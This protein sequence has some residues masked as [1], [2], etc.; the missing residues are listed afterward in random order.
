MWERTPDVQLNKPLIERSIAGRLN[1]FWWGD[2]K[3]TARR[4]NDVSAD[5]HMRVIKRNA[6]SSGDSP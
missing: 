5:T 2:E 1:R 4:T 3:C 6:I